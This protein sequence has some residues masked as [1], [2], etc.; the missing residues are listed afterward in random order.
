M[1]N[2][3]QRIE[4]GK[5]VWEVG[6]FR[7]ERLSEKVT[8]NK[9]QMKWRSQWCGWVEGV[10]SG[11]RMFQAEGRGGV[12]VLEPGWAWQV[13]V[14]QGLWCD[15]SRGNKGVYGRGAAHGL[16]GLP[17]LNQIPLSKSG[18]ESLPWISYTRMGKGP[19]LHRLVRTSASI[20]SLLFLDS[21]RPDFHS[22]KQ[23]W[24]SQGILQ[25]STSETWMSH[26]VSPGRTRTRQSPALVQRAFP[27]LWACSSSHRLGSLITLWSENTPLCA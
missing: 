5:T 19:K 4:L 12:T 2:L 21:R 22:S 9:S 14:Q 7:S 10:G 25:V 15:G 17:S 6:F 8:F 24:A 1:L 20:Q 18:P 11:E 26:T 23:V 13:V 3:K 27:V 16:P